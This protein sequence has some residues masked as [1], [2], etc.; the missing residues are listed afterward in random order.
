[1]VQLIAQLFS[2]FLPIYQQIRQ[3]YVDQHGAEPTDADITAQFEQHI[4]DI[5][6][7]GAAW[8]ASHPK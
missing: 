4:A 5:V 1:M 8:Q 2:A 6:A 3:Q 7:E